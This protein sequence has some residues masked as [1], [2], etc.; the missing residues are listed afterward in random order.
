MEFRALLKEARDNVATA[1]LTMEAMETALE[2]AEADIYLS[3]GDLGKNETERKHRLDVIKSQNAMYQQNKLNHTN[4]VAAYSAARD[5]LS[6]IEDARRDFENSMRVAFLNA[7]YNV[8]VNDFSTP[9]FGE[10]FKA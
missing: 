4:A 1:K 9:L 8:Q 10:T 6:E 2:L 3:A 5:R 7:E